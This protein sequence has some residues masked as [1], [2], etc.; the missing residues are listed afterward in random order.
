[1]KIRLARADA[2]FSKRMR[3]QAGKCRRCGKTGRLECAHIVSRRV[4]E[5]RWEERNVV[6]LC[7]TCHR[8]LHE[9]PL[10]G[11]DWLKQELGARRLTWLK[12]IAAAPKKVRETRRSP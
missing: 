6:V 12:R 5:L 4:R 11:T 7:F 2:E 1:M 3:E 10:A 9:N 8:W